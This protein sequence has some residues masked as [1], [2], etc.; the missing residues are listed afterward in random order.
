MVP[1]WTEKARGVRRRLVAR[2]GD[3]DLAIIGGG[4]GGYHWLVSRSGRDLAEGSERTL[5]TA[6]AAAEDA[7][8]R[9][10]ED[11]E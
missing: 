11:G 10:V 7:A 3:L 6:K 1:Q 9:L 2:M 4:S 8:R 5:V